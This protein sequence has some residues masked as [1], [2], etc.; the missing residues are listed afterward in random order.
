MKTGD[1]IPNIP[2]KALEV[3]PIEHLG[4]RVV[5]ASEHLGGGVVFTKLFPTPEAI[6]LWR[7]GI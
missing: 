1:Y 4:G 7:M 3:V 5:F 2:K 6:V